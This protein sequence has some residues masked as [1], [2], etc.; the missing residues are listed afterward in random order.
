MH[1]YNIFISFNFVA[2]SYINTLPQEI[3]FEKERSEILKRYRSLLKSIP[4]KLEA[5][6]AKQ[7]REAFEMALEAHKNMRRKSGE[8]YIYHPLAVAKI[9]AQ[10]MGLGPTAIICSLLHDVVED[11]EITLDD[12]KKK[13]GERVATIIDGLTKISGVFDNKGSIQAEN[14][15]KMLLT[16]SDDVRVILIKLCDRLHNMRT[17]E[18]MPRS[19]QLKI[20]SETLYL[21][22]PLAHRLGLNAIKTEL[23]DQA[24]KYT[25]PETYSEIAQKLSEKKTSRSK[26]IKE[27]I[28]PLSQKL[29]DAGLK[30]FQIK[31]RPKSIFGIMKK[32]RTQGVSFEEVFDLFAVRII[33]ESNPSRETEL[34]ECWKVY[35]LVTSAYTPNTSRTRDWITVPK[36]NGYE[37]LHTTVLGPKGKWVEV[38]IRTERMDEIAEK[39]YAAHWKYKNSKDDISVQNDSGLDAWLA[40]VKDMME[41]PSPNTLEFLDDFKLNLFSEEMFV[42][43]PKGDLY[44]LPKESTALDFAFEIHSQVGSRCIGA[45]VNGKLVPINSKLHN[46]DTV[47]IITSLKQ[48]PTEDWIKLVVTGKAKSKIRQFLREEK[49]VSAEDGK[50]K[51]QR[52]FRNKQIPLSPETLQVLIHHF[53]QQSQLDFYYSISTGKI[54]LEKLDIDAILNKPAPVKTPSELPEEYKKGL[55]T[56]KDKGEIIVGDDAGLDYSLAMCCNPIPG[57]PI[58]GFI[59]IGEGIKIHRTNCPNAISLMSNYGYR[60][61]KTQWRHYPEKEQFFLAGIQIH[62]IDDVGVISRVTDIISKE[63][64]LK[65]KSISVDS[66]Q[67]TFSGT[68]M[69]YINNTEHLEALMKKIEQTN[70]YM[71]VTRMNL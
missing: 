40:R 48:K 65:M 53:K 62:G 16:L 1:P 34:A 7:L 13:F 36:E 46:G 33:L 60:I 55:K 54:E 67:G 68:I 31:G 32:M 30:N 8:P 44:K 43:S 10:E 50:V 63:L 35:S 29:K 69:V 25:E 26:Y 18:S 57:D 23:E 22:G 15:R 24:L 28:D 5:V 41:S 14:F 58:F 61:I 51:L 45:K 3:N 49:R 27:F 64:Q 47:E 21:Y 11:T 56:A 42:F 19:N 59:T 66:E 38:Q 12:I 6:E 20:A 4:R 70:K 37:S 71:K 39:G 2:L 52:K 17:L 9:A